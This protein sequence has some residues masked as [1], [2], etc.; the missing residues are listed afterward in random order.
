MSIVGALIETTD[1]KIKKSNFGVLTA[2]SDKGNNEVYALICKDADNQFNTLEQFGVTRIIRISSSKADLMK[3]PDLM[4]GAIIR[5]MEEYGIMSL[6]GLSS[7]IGKDLLS[8]I[9]SQINKP[10]IQD[11]IDVDL[12]KKTVIKSHFSGKTTAEVKIAS[13]YFISGIRPNAIEPVKNPCKAEIVSFDALIDNPA[14][15]RIKEIKQIDSNRLDLT[16]A[17]IIISG[18]RPMGSE[19]NFSTLNECASKLGAAVGASR[20]AVDAGF[21]PHGIQVG[22]TG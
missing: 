19:K 13:D 16:E 10:V 12:T 9:A 21:A 20:S 15:V 1:G 5:T 14:G 4:A 18:G 7:P 2:A 11:C 22:Q 17:N 3:S 6:I 8:R